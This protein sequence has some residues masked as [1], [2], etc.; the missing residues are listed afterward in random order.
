MCISRINSS[1]LGYVWST[2][3]CLQLRIF[4]AYEKRKNPRTVR[5][6]WSTSFIPSRFTRM[7]TAPDLAARVLLCCWMSKKKERGLTPLACFLV[8]TTWVV[9]VCLKSSGDKD[10][11][12]VTD[13]KIVMVGERR[14]KL[15]SAKVFWKLR[16]QGYSDTELKHAL[17]ITYLP[18]IP[19]HFFRTIMRFL[20]IT[21]VVSTYDGWQDADTHSTCK[22]KTKQWE[23]TWTETFRASKNGGHRRMVHY[24]RGKDALSQGNHA[25]RSLEF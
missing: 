9:G 6:V 21:Q 5:L 17:K 12:R 15:S 19:D 8:E 11:E 16:R 14:E 18:S 10:Y 22:K 1:S 3:K 25:T 20:P 23:P 13:L 24:S 7:Q 4:P 2:C